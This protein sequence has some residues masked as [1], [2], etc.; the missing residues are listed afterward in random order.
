MTATLGGRGPGEQHSAESRVRQALW[1]TT[2]GDC[3]VGSSGLPQGTHVRQQR[4]GK[5][6]AGPVPS[7]GH[8]P[9]PKACEDSQQSLPTRIPRHPWARGGP[10]KGPGRREGFFLPCWPPLDMHI[11]AVT[12]L[13]THVHMR[14]H[15]HRHTRACT[16]TDAAQEWLPR[17]VSLS[18][19]LQI[20]C[21]QLGTVA[22]CIFSPL[23]K[24]TS[25]F[26]VTF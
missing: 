15:F 21:H 4:E 13:Y 6:G 14:V 24:M 20:L 17:E 16:H 22:L 25:E 9:G 12:P 1:V 5:R 10:A 7:R 11:H 23:A 2:H 18:Y 3:H 8:C 26:L 19:L